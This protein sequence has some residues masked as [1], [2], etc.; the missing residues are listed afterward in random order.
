MFNERKKLTFPKGHLH[1]C[2][3]AFPHPLSLKWKELPQLLSLS[4][5][6][7]KQEYHT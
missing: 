7:E 6:I 1:A 4:P 3:L 2:Y 5:E